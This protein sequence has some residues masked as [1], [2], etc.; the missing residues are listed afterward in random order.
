MLCVCVLRVYGAADA[1]RARVWG[2]ANDANAVPRAI[3]YCVS[4]TLFVVTVV[5]PSQLGFFFL[6]LLSVCRNRARAHM[7]LN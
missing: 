4:Q 5:V 2:R 1:N 7:G 6:G 3:V